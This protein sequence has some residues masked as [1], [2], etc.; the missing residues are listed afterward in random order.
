MMK[1]SDCIVVTGAAGLVGSAVVEYLRQQMHTC[2]IGLARLDC[3]LLNQFDTE[4]VFRRIKPTHV[5]HAAARVYGI[6]GNMANQGKSFLE[7]TRINTNVVDAARLVGVEKITVMGTNCVYP[8]PAVLPFQEHTVFDGRPDASESAYGHAKRGMLAMLE[9]YE[10]SY[11]M[12]WAYLVSGNV[13]GIRDRFDPVSG[14]VIPSMVQKFY[15]A[16]ISGGDVELWGDGTPE[17]DFL[18]VRDLARVAHLVMSEDVRGAINVG[19]G[20]SWSIAQVAGMLCNI[21][22]VSR[23]RIRWNPDK[24]NGRMQCYADLSRQR[25]LGFAPAYSLEGGL[26][27]TWSWYKAKRDGESRP[28]GVDWTLQTR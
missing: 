16:S 8:S 17:R 18:Y 11:G 27:E 6:G 19:Y 13:Y 28:E 1:Q 23:S 9:A 26:R 22:G 4:K 20:Y 21:T 12:Q 14:H 24:P 15:E 5:F 2:V 10:E 3:D 25:S 7:N